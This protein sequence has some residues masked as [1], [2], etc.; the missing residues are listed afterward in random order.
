[1]SALSYKSVHKIISF[2][3][4]V[5]FFLLIFPTLTYS[6]LPSFGI[7]KNFA[8]FILAL[9]IV[10]PVGH[11]SSLWFVT[12]SHLSLFC[13]I[14]LIFHV[15]FGKEAWFV[16]LTLGGFLPFVLCAV[17]LGVG[18]FLAKKIRVKR[19]DVGEGKTG[20]RIKIVHLTDMHPSRMFSLSTVRYIFT[21]VQRENP[22]I[23]AM[24]GDIFDENTS[25]EMFDKYCV[26]FS[27]LMPK[28]G[29]YY[30]FGNHDA[31]WLWKKP[32]HTKEDIINSLAAANVRVLEDEEVVT[33]GGK[34]R[35][36]GRRDV[37]ENRKSPEE[38]LS[39]HSGDGIYN[40]LLCHEPLELKKC[41]DSGANLTLCGHTHGGQIF[42]I[43][44]LSS[45]FGINEMRYGI[46]KFGENSY[47][48]VSS[49]VGTWK[50]PIRTESRSE[51][52]V[53]NVLM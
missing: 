46:K 36:I 33:C 44:V 26:M 6:S 25:P 48:E 11:A 12:V 50:Y 23:I 20:E 5:I 49:G 2:F 8:A 9:I 17:F 35:I 28:H 45:L 53:I 40:V 10:L 39:P 51:I 7:E 21:L 14:Y 18:L 29:V 34:V 24:T 1:M 22:D 43:G 4:L 37:T 38:L 19:Y 27:E 52:A 47:A 16:G 42:P 13:G 3:S 31:R 30:V 41:A 32:A 15:F